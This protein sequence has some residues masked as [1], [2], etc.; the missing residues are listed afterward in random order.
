MSEYLFM[1][2][3]QL[4]DWD[5]IEFEMERE[6]LKETAEDSA[7]DRHVTIV[8]EVIKATMDYFRGDGAA[9]VDELSVMSEARSLQFVSFV[10]P[11]LV[12]IL[13]EEGKLDQAAAIAGK[14]LERI[15][16]VDLIPE[17]FT[18]RVILSY[19]SVR[20][21][22][23]RG[24]REE[25]LKYLSELEELSSMFE[26]DWIHTYHSLALSTFEEYFGDLTRAIALLSM[27]AET[28][29]RREQILD[30]AMC[31][32]GLALMYQKRGGEGEK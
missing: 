13:V 4:G 6:C 24:N 25:A 23:L 5:V 11:I 20:I 31:S 21:N 2:S 1:V 27:S 12:C 15:G 16:K 29:R 7:E 14:A 9:H 3:L 10:L 8:S 26:E 28:F 30:Y 17:I 19:F 32:Y 18:G 22:A